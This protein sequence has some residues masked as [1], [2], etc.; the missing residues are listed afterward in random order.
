MITEEEYKKAQAIV[1][2]YHEERQ[3]E[4]DWDLED[5]DFDR[6][7]AEDEEDERYQEEYETALNCSCGAWIIRDN[8]VYHIADCF[9]GA[10]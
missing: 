10:E 7:D 2:Q 6:G 5:D 3:R 1:D 4:A 8:T 9:C